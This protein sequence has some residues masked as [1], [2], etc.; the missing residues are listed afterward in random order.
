[1]FEGNQQQDAHEVKIHMI[2]FVKK[3]LF[4]RISKTKL[5]IFFKFSSFWLLCWP[6]WETSKLQLHPPA[7]EDV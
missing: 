4:F 5:Y 3:T 2:V 1:M 7:S 6:L